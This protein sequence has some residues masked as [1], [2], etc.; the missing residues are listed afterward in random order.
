MQYT[1][2]TKFINRRKIALTKNV[3]IYLMLHSDCLFIKRFADFIEIK[4]FL[5]YLFSL[6]YIRCAA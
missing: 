4:K 5:V 6:F 2:F 1:K 3:N